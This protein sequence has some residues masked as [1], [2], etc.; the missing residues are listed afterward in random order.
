MDWTSGWCHP[1]L[2]EGTWGEEGGEETVVATGAEV[3]GD[4]MEV[5]EQEA[6]VRASGTE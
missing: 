5:L 4:K 1:M 6:K 3:E 2:G